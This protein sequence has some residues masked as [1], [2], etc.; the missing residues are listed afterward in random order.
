MWSGPSQKASA[1]L[2]PTGT[3]KQDGCAVEKSK[4]LGL[5]SS[6]SDVVQ[7]EAENIAWPNPRMLVSFPMEKDMTAV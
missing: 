1:S 7:H 4:W 2:L 3:G 6:K 5:G